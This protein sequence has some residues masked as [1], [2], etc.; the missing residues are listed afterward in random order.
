MKKSIVVVFILLLVQGCFLNRRTKTGR[1]PTVRNNVCKV[2]S[3]KVIFYAVFVDSKGIHPWS[4]YDLNSTKDSINKA[5]N[6]LENEAKKNSIGLD[7]EFKY[8]SKNDRLPVRGKFKYE[9]LSSTLF[10]FRDIRKGIK[11]VD[12]WSDKISRLVAKGLPR[13]KS[14]QAI[15]KN[16]MTDRERLIA[17]LR[18]LYGT[19]NIALLFFTNN[20][21][22]NEMSVALHT[23]SDLNTEY[24]IVSEKRPA[25]IAHEFLHL[26]G[27]ED[28]YISQFD[29]GG[30]SKRKKEKIM[31]YFP[32]E[33]MAFA[34]RDI[35]SLG[36]S[37]L[38]KYLIGWDNILDE[39]AKGLITRK[40]QKL[41]EY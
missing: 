26:F 15:T 5:I 8:Y 28:L 12:D 13:K 9:T 32:N 22:E 36:I 16:N 19:D 18:D 4:D 14:E 33:I 21:F 40:G 31:K 2:L 27:A 17:K 11:S 39:N 30:K 29:R 35:D 24:A 6:W 10:H 20:Y 41:L 23:A 1:Y 7:I 34:Y 25:V 38:S 37:P 3:N